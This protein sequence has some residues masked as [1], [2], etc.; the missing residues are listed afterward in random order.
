VVFGTVVIS[1]SIDD[2]SVLLFFPIHQDINI[3]TIPLEHEEC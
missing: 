3:S 2:D 1:H